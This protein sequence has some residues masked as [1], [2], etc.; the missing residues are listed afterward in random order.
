MLVE[1]L[2]LCRVCDAVKDC[3]FFL[4][5]LYVVLANSHDASGNSNL[6]SVVF[7]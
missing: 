4:L 6:D 7:V 3:T 1:S 2:V 5:V